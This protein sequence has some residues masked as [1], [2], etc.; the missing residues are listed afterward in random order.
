MDDAALAELDHERHVE[1]A[2]ELAREAGERG[3]GPYGSVLVRDGEVV[4][5]S[6]NREETRDDIALH[7]E[8]SLARRAAR[9]ATP[10]ERARTVMYTST[11]PCSMCATG[12]AFAGLGAVVYSVSGARAAELAGRAPRG[13]PSEEVFDRWNADVTVRGPVRPEAGDAVHEAYR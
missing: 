5:E 13:I 1:R 4:A 2:V 7:P 10:A 3:D 11:E 9:E 12:I 6:S 8:L